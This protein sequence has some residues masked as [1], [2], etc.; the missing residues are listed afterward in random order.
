MAVMMADTSRIII[1]PIDLHGINR[2]T[3]EVLVRI[4]HQLDRSLLGLLL[5][6]LRLQRVAD[7]PFTTEITL[8]GGRERSLLRDH[9]TQRQSQVSD[10]TRR[11]LHELA[12]RDRVDLAFEDA[13]GARWHTALERE[14]EGDV[15]FPARQRWRATSPGRVERPGFIRRLGL[16]VPG[17]ELPPASLVAAAALLRAGLVGDVYVIC[18]RP[19]LPEQLQGLFRAGHQVRVQTNFRCDANH[20]IALILQSHYDLLLL[21][22]ECLHNI[23]AEALDAALDRSGSQVMV[24]S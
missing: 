18:R 9:L 13:A 12:N 23:P 7:L 20:L 14:N 21:P 8:S 1:V 17:D 2:H 22:R 5:E 15:F 24:V 3:L 11:L 10:E 16:V 6:D 19:L 4:A